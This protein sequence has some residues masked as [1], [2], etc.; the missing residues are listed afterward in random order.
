MFDIRDHGG[1]FQGN[2]DDTLLKAS[3]TVRISRNVT[4]TLT[5]T[6]TVRTY[7]VPFQLKVNKAGIIRMGGYVST[8]YGN[9]TGTCVVYANGSAIGSISGTYT[10]S[11]F[12]KRD[13]NVKKGDVLTFRLSS[14]APTGNDDS[15]RLFNLAF[16]YDLSDTKNYLEGVDL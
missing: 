12:A 8:S 16:Y 3:D 2:K 6:S 15:V 11:G 13:L 14:N 9:T 5:Q 4:Y 7:T 1:I 10:T